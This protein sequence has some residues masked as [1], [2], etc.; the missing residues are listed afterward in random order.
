MTLPIFAT[1]MAGAAAL[2]LAT[3]L[4]EILFT[5][6]DGKDAHRP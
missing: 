5:P 1:M 6:G 3:L 2:G 4:L